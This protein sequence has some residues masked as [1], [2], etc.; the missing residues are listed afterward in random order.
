MKKI[1]FF[2]LTVLFF[3]ACNTTRMQMMDNFIEGSYDKFS[4]S[5]ELKVNIAKPDFSGEWAVGFREIKASKKSYILYAYVFTN[6][7]M[8]IDHIAFI[9]DGKDRISFQSVD[10]DRVVM[11]GMEEGSI[12]EYAYFNSDLKFIQ[13]LAKAEKIEIK[14]S[15]KRTFKELKFDAADIAKLN[16]Y[17]EVVSGQRPILPYFNQ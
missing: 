6:S 5:R 15:G 10:D 8:F 13:S 14:I 11:N 1:M 9:V 2:V 4:G 7:W 16:E 3:T 17:C 12:T